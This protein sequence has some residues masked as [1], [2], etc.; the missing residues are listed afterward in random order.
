M[1]MAFGLSRLEMELGAHGLRSP[2]AV[3][4]RVQQ[5]RE[6]QAASCCQ[7]RDHEHLLSDFAA[8]VCLG[9][10]SRTVALLLLRGRVYGRR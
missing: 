7:V 3:T 4:I 2:S 10:P 6:L 5:L 8:A 9:L 1:K